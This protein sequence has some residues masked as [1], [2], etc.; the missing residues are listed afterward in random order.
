MSSWNKHYHWKTKGCTPWAKQWFTEKLVGVSA[1][2]KSNPASKVTV[3]SLSEF[4]GDVE[5]GNRKGK[6]IT[7]YDCSLKLAWS[8]EDHD[9]DQPKVN[10]TITFPE[11]SH[12]IEDNQESY[13]FETELS[14][15]SSD[16][17][18]ALYMV[19]RNSLAPK[20]EQILHDFRA[21]LI[22]THAK[23]LGHEDSPAQPSSAKESSSV[24][25]TTA[26]TSSK[27]SQPQAGSVSTS[28][29]PIRTSA[30][31]A[32]SQADLW[33]LLTNPARIPMWSKAPAQ[34]WLNPGANYSLFGGNITGSVE[35][36]DAPHKLVQTWRV[37][38][39]P[40]GHYGKFTTTLTQSEDST[41]LELS[42]SGVPTSQED[43]T[44][45][46]LENYY[47]RGL[48]SIGLGTLL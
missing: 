39:W 46:G 6:L 34:L 24:N 35:S 40:S 21:E 17:A 47:I 8:S 41:L 3:D 26:D 29:A 19:V 45:A 31:L 11:V 44:K 18:H 9:D 36:V 5:L 28:R 12:E 42:L 30:Q 7:I 37:P 1:E 43:G 38:Q 27:T 48:K 33:D 4:D 14:S 2:D 32:I 13:R 16:T 15:G 10:G 25:H 22:E 20:L 23:D